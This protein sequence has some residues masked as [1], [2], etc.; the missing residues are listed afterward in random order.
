MIMSHFYQK[1]RQNLFRKVS[2][3]FF[4]LTGYL[5]A[6]CCGSVYSFYHNKLVEKLHL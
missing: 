5:Q 6:A 1:K 4:I 3:I 2:S